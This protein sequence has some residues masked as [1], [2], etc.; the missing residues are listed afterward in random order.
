MKEPTLEQWRQLCSELLEELL[1]AHR[2]IANL[3]QDLEEWRALEPHVLNVFREIGDVV[4][5]VAARVR[6]READYQRMLP[7]PR[8]EER[9]A[10]IVRL[11]EQE[12]VSFGRMGRCLAAMNPAWVHKDGKPLS[13]AAAEKA[14]HRHKSRRSGDTDK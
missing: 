6:K 3:W 13:R 10:A 7:K 1:A 8:K 2:L 5:Q 12:G 11:H 4:E 9:D 14:Y